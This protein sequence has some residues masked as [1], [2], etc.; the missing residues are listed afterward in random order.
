MYYFG[1]FGLEPIHPLGQGF[2]LGIYSY[3]YSPN[4]KYLGL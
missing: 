4:L 1:F 3:I 2:K